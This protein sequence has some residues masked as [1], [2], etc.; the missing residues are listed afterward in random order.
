MKF[1]E[2]HSTFI[3]LRKAISVQVSRADPWINRQAMRKRLEREH[4]LVGKYVGHDGEKQR[5][6]VLR[7]G[8]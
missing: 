2:H 5:G 3:R 7:R 6:R 1:T 4:G 8:W